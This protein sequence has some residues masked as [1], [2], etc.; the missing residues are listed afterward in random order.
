MRD[1]AAA[2]QA[3]RDV[4]SACRQFLHLW[5]M[6]CLARRPAALD[7]LLADVLDASPVACE[8]SPSRHFGD[9][10]LHRGRDLDD[11]W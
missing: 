2:A 1:L 7:R 10:R 4:H 11:E 8:A 3:L 6:E 9:F 5:V